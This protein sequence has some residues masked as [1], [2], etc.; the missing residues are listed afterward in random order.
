MHQQAKEKR[1]RYAPAGKGEEGQICTNRP[2]IRGP[3]MQ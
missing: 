3:D 2:R 1:D